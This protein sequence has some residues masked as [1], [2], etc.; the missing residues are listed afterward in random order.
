MQK[1]KERLI[2][3]IIAYGYLKTPAIIRAFREVP[4]EEF[5]ED[6]YKKYAYANE[7]LPIRGGQT[8]S[9]PLT[10]AAMTEALMPKKG[11]KILE[12]G[13]G[14][15]YQAA[16]LAEIVG[17]KGKIITL[18]R[19]KELCEFAQK[20]LSK[21]GYKNI[22]VIHSD[23]VDGYPE[24]A[25]YDRIVVTASATDIPKPLID[26]LKKG[27]R[28]VIPVGN[29]MILVEKNEEVKKTFLGYYA[30]VPLLSGKE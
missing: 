25:P 17:P 9:Q 27:G 20:N 10:V 30:F 21:R 13:A 5:V 11:D 23:G 1:E 24:E 8:I 6:D 26:Q 7:P 2:R 12:L 18:E 28:L 19:K 29:E 4:R 16:I 14:S 22:A 3:E 15:G